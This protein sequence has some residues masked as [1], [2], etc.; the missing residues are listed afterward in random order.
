MKFDHRDLK[1]A[2]DETVNVVLRVLLEARANNAVI[3]LLA[4]DHLEI[5][6]DVRRGKVKD[7]RQVVVSRIVVVNLD[8]AKDLQADRTAGP[9]AH[10]IQNALWKMQCVL[11]PTQTESS[12]KKS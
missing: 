2:R 6:R 1:V 4:I 12:A 10:R 9:W 8:V 3:D 5:V 7:L 11:M